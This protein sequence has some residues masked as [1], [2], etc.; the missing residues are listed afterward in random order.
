MDGL[1]FF[2]QESGVSGLA[3]ARGF[4]LI[5]EANRKLI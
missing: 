4:L 1:F 3:F 2:N 5:Q